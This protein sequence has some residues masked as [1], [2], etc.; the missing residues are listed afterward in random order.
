M[1][2]DGTQVSES[3]LLSTNELK[4]TQETKYSFVVPVYN[5]GYLASNFCSMLELVMA[6]Y[7]RKTD[8]SQCVELI[9]INDGSQDDSLNQLI[10]LKSSYNF[11]KIISLSRNFGQ[12]QA[13]AAGLHLST[14]DYV[15]RS[16]IDMQEPLSEVPRFLDAIKESEYDIVIGQYS[17]R[18]SSFV[19]KLTSGAYFHLFKLLTGI[20]TPSNSS[21]LRVMSRR[22]VDR[23]SSL[24]EKNHFPQGIVSILGFKQKYIK[25]EHVK[26]VD[27]GSA[28]SFISRLRMGVNGMLY[29]SERPLQLVASF[30]FLCATAGFFGS[31]FILIQH[32]IGAKSVAGYASLAIFLLFGIGL[33]I[34]FTGLVGLYVGKIFTEVKNRPL[35]IVENIY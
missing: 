18:K 27:G 20:R 34:G 2:L 29:F 3:C 6:Q 21:P 30:G 23:Y 32:L 15:V 35:Y 9:F 19:T 24:V 22:Y 7:V 28:Y 12:H 1:E 25:V 5:D 26:R 14:G 33:Q 13:I 4:S 8:L 17:K 11:I 10:Q 16:N 31:L